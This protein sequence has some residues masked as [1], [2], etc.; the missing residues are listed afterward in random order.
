VLQS[1]S[2]SRDGNMGDMNSLT[3]A[4]H[5]VAYSGH[6]DTLMWHLHLCSNFCGNP[7]NR[8][9]QVASFVALVTDVCA[10]TVSN[11][12]E[13]SGAD[14][15]GRQ[16]QLT[17]EQSVKVISNV[18]FSLWHEFNLTD[19]PYDTS[20]F[21]PRNQRILAAVHQQVALRLEKE[22]GFPGWKTM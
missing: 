9:D 3:Q 18:A 11:F 1:S 2:S 8:K 19:E 4:F 5:T 6:F 22:P 20:G 13:S 17:G 14:A 16:A 15:G 12:V 10:V 21:T 7:C